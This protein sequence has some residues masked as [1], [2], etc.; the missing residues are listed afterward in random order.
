MNYDRIFKKDERVFTLSLL[1]LYLNIIAVELY[2]VLREAYGEHV[3]SCVNDGLGV[4]K[5]V[6]SMVQTRNVENSQK[7]EDVEF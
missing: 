3:A 7:Y 1:L 6:T 4:S 5:E 2:R